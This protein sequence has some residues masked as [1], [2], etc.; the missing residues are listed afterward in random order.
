[1]EES[2]E[3]LVARCQQGSDHAFEALVRRYQPRIIRFLETRL[4]NR[5]DAE[6]ATQQTFLQAHGGIGRFK[7]GHRFA[8]WLFTI[9]RRQGIDT[10]RRSGS[11][12]R[13]AE[14]LRAEPPPG[15][16]VDPS[17]LL[18]QQED[19]DALWHWIRTQLDSRSCE[20]L[21]LRIQEDMDLA[22]I[23]AIMKLTRTH[24]KVLLHRAR[25]SLCETLLSSA[26]EPGPV[27][28]TAA[29]ASQSCPR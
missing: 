13:L 25:K 6:D 4:N 21:W 23:A 8:P 14:K 18:G 17:K 9:A 29:P 11:R 19:V 26:T 5:Q 1:M 22:E 24:V 20:I 10:L 7:S 27:E 12:R 16:A 3:D 15:A 2:D 28:T